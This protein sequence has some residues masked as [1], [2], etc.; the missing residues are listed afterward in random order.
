MSIALLLR[1]VDQP[2]GESRQIGQPSVA[3]VRPELPPLLQPTPAEAVLEV[4]FRA[5]VLLMARS[6]V[7]LFALRFEPAIHPPAALARLMAASDDQ[8]AAPISAA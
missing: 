7:D 6:Q 2:S 4:A 8:A 5:R 1:R 3:A